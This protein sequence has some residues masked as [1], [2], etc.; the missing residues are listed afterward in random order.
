MKFEVTRRHAGSGI[1]T[2]EVTVRSEILGKMNMNPYWENQK[3][4][5]NT[6]KEISVQR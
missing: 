5:A 2:A 3:L 6:I 1:H 4:L